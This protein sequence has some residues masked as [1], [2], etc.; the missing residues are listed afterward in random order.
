MCPVM[1]QEKI[2]ATSHIRANCFGDKVYVVEIFSHDLDWRRNLNCEFRPYELSAEIN[3]T[4]VKLIAALGLQMGIMDL[5]VSNGEVVWLEIN[6]QGQF[7]FAEGLSGLD[8]KRP[9]AEFFKSLGQAR[10]ECIPGASDTEVGYRS[11]PNARRSSVS[12]CAT[13]RRVFNLNV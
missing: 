5:I 11:T 6:P 2:T 10:I 13:K 3:D 8:L 12:V 1:F 4:L 7:L 9:C